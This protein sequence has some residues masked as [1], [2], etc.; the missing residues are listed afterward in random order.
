MHPRA[1]QAA[2]PQ[3]HE[4]D[5]PRDGASVHAKRGKKALR[6][7]GPASEAI[8]IE[9][10]AGAKDGNVRRS[11]V[12]FLGEIGTRNQSI[13]AL[14]QLAIQNPQDRFLNNEIANAIKTINFRGK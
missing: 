11:Y 5:R 2:R 1:W 12:Q 6:E 9:T 14:Q 8:V 10:L 3:R 4:G 13:P 7:Y